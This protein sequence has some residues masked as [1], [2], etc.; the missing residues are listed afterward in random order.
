MISLVDALKVHVER[1]RERLYANGRYQTDAIFYHSCRLFVG[2]GERAEKY[3]VTMLVKSQN[4]VDAEK[5]AESHLRELLN[6]QPHRFGDYPS[7][8][9]LKGRLLS[10]RPK[11][12]ESETTLELLARLRRGSADV[13]S[14]FER[15]DTTNAIRVGEP[16]QR[17]ISS[18]DRFAEDP[19]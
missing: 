12:D 10:N 3:R 8:R 5:V 9:W 6:S 7:I 14:T 16:F 2:R 18:S 15:I 17:A 11:D 13:E 4:C 19:R 1:V